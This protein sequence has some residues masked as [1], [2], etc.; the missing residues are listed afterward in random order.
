MKYKFK[1]VNLDLSWGKN[2]NNDGGFILKYEEQKLLGSGQLIFYKS[3]EF[4]I[5][6]TKQTGEDFVEQAI[7]FWLD[8]LVYEND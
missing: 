8:S 5:C 3:G 1:Y 7:K 4:T 2:E 6:D